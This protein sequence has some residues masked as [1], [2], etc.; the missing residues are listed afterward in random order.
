M[1]VS[2]LM[3]SVPGRMGLQMIDMVESVADGDDVCKGYTLWYRQV[4]VGKLQGTRDKRKLFF[5]GRLPCSLLLNVINL[6][7]F[8]G[9]TG[10]S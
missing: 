2:R 6:M 1:A 8:L 4:V 3:N 7:V 5:R 9:D 10:A